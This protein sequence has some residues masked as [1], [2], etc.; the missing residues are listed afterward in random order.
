M[1]GQQYVELLDPLVLCYVRCDMCGHFYPQ[2]DLH[3]LCM[4][5]YD[6]PRLVLSRR[7]QTILDAHPFTVASVTVMSAHGF[8]E[9][10]TIRS[11]QGEKPTQDL[12]VTIRFALGPKRLVKV[13]HTCLISEQIY[14]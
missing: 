1:S 3:I 4:A 10:C 9:H 11:C 13:G 7:V 2:G 5:E 12:T 14:M 6:H 8:S